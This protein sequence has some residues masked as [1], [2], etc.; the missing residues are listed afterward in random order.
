MTDE[1]EID[2]AVRRRKIIFRANHRGM[3]EMDVVL[4]GYVARHIENMT[5]DE[6]NELERIIA[7]QDNDLLAWLTKREEVPEE[8]RSQMLSDILAFSARP[9]DYTQT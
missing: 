1:I 2:N 7:L 9:E 4:G 5:P 8:H 3:K 6:L